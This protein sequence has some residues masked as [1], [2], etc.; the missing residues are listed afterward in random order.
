MTT[1]ETD[2]GGR[3]GRARP[4]LRFTAVLRR[5]PRFVMEEWW[6]GT[7]GDRGSWG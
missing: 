7:G 5:E 6:R 4:P 2:A 1:V 3:T